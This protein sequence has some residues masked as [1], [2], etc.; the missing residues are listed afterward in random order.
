MNYDFRRIVVGYQ[1][2]VVCG[3]NNEKM[4]KQDVFDNLRRIF[5]KLEVV[6]LYAIIIMYKC[7]H[8]LSSDLAKLVL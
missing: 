6:S 1:P 4:D 5:M 7:L 2:L 3:E 8:Y